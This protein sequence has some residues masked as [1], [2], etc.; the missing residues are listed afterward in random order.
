MD[1]TE[2]YS[3]LKNVGKDPSALVFEDELTGL[4]NRRFCLNYLQHKLSWD[5][6]DER[7][8]SLLMMDID[9]FKEVNDTYGHERVDEALIHVSS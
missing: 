4:H 7:R 9:Y 6:P 2:L 8:V 1:N 5:F 3:Y